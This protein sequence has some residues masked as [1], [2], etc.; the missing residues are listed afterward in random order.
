MIS[1]GESQTGAEDRLVENTGT[2]VVFSGLSQLF[3][4]DAEVYMGTGI[5]MLSGTS[6]FQGSIDVL[7]TLGINY[8]YVL[9]DG[10]YNMYYVYIGENKNYNLREIA[11]EFGGKTIEI[12]AQKDIIN[13]LYFGDR[14]TFVELPQYKDVK[15]NVF[16]QYGSALWMIQD[17]A[18]QYKAHK[19]Y[20]RKLFTGK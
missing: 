18:S 6:L 2:T 17:D 7:K 10:Q 11:Q 5:A 15:V 16:I 3:G 4:D 20:I 14:V 12:Y 1:T 9:K 8:E 19:K 13:N